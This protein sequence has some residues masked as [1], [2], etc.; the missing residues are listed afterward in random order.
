MLDDNCIF[1][2]IIKKEIPA[3]IIYEDGKILAFLDIRPRNPGHT[4]IIPKEH[5]QTI[6]E[7]SEEEMTEIYKAARKIAMALKQSIEC[8]GVNIIQSNI[9]SQG[10]PHFHTH[11]IPRFF[12]DGMPIVWESNQEAS[13]EELQNI[14]E[15]IKNK[16]EE[17]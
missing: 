12:D 15:K 10:V 9:V 1:C 5:V 7:I 11:V 4:L 8:D 13:L 17:I 14:A 3:A 16:I 2:K 6:F